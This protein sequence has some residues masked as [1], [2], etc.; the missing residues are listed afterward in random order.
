M[1]DRLIVSSSGIR[2]VV[3]D[4]LDPA[5]ALRFAA[6]YGTL[7][8]DGEASDGRGTAG[9]HLLLGRDSRVSGPVLAD[10]VAAGLRAVG[11]SV[12]DA[13]VVATP[14]GLLAIQDD[15]DARG[16]ILVTASHNPPEWN[17]LK[18]A[19]PG[20]EF[21]SPADGREVQRLFGDGPA[22]TDWEGQGGRSEA[23]GAVEHHV[24]RILGLELTD[25]AGVAAAGLTV[26]VDTVR[27]AGGPV[28]TRL[29]EAMGCRVEGLDLEPDG[30]FPRD[31]EPRPENLE[32]LG[33]RVRSSGADLGLAVDPDGDRL[34][35]VDDAGRPVGEDLTLAL[36]A[37]YVLR[38]RSGPVV[39]NLSTS[40][41][42]RDVAE[43]A[44]AA[45][46]LA[47]VGEANV[48]ARMREVDAVVGGEGNGGVMLPALHLTRDAP[49]AAA[50]V[51]SGLAGEGG[52]LRETVDDLPG[53]HIAKSRAPRPDA[54]LEPVYAAMLEA[55]GDG[56][57]ADRQ[58]GLRLDWPAER[59]WV[60]VRPSGTE[61]IVRLIAEAPQA[62]EADRLVAW[63]RERLEAALG[64]N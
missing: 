20:G 13:G 42:V 61:P 64:G 41:V 32:R 35:L 3:G 6:A 31:P 51:L 63:A 40:R 46:H 25:A 8:R 59:R 9:G 30:R 33:E 49:L 27:G 45:L 16:G 18:L 19:T 39:T 26:A 23:P 34:A 10:A 24:E 38:H 47:P 2:G 21:V 60:H 7:L 54:A 56:A 57:D 53:Y 1:P 50:L 22:W 44:G 62:E 58:D 15:S 43:A 48:A 37:R 52:T 29:L 11:W 4:G 12:R 36:V 5:T 28:M 17:G 55:A 14:T